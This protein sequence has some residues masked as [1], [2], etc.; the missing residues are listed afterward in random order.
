[1]TTIHDLPPYDVRDDPGPEAYQA[2]LREAAITG[3]CPVWI[4]PRTAGSTDPLGTR[5]G[6]AQLSPTDRPGLDR[7]RRRRLLE[8]AQVDAAALLAGRWR[9]PCAPTCCPAPLPE[10]PG[11]TPRPSRDRTEPAVA[12]AGRWARESHISLDL[13]IVDAARPA[14]VPAAVGWL[15]GGNHGQE[16]TD[17]SAVLRT[18]EERFGAMLVLMT[19]ST[20]WLA[21]AEPPTTRVESEQV[22]AE[23]FAFCPDQQD[24]QDGYT[25]YGLESYGAKIRGDRM[26]RFW[27]D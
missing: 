13:A 17:M 25:W 1:M 7:L 27:W 20:L 23:H 9:G 6:R 12:E 21:V 16:A 10:W 22:A 4:S 24:P 26:W 14:D 15:G 11:L 8:V 5:S 19:E 2:L 3:R 18:W